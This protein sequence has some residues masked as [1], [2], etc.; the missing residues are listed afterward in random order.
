MRLDFIPNAMKKLLEVSSR[1]DPICCIPV[2]GYSGHCVEAG[3]ELQVKERSLGGSCCS[4]PG[5]REHQG[6]GVR[7]FPH[8]AKS[9][10]L[11]VWLRGRW[12]D[13]CKFRERPGRRWVTGVWAVFE[14]TRPDEATQ[15]EYV[16]IVRKEAWERVD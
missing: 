6:L 1:N 14:A 15:G 3:L 16:D 10:I 8:L 13:Q 2:K 11:L 12:T 5:K 4:Q 9:Q 7:C